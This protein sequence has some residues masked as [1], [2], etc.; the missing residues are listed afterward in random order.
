MVAVFVSEI[1][2]APKCT[3]NDGDKKV[4]HH[5]GVHQNA[6]DIEKVER[7]QIIDTLWLPEL[8]HGQLESVIKGVV[9]CLEP[10][11]VRMIGLA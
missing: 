9:A 3:A 5:D 2:D 8:S 4:G 7:V 10:L 1:S 11:V 6:G